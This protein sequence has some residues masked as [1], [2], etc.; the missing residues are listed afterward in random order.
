MSCR[1]PRLKR[2]LKLGALGG[3]IIGVA[4]FMKRRRQNMTS[5]SSWPTLADTAAEQGHSV[6]TSAEHTP[7]EDAADEAADDPGHGRADEAVSDE[8]V[9][10][11]SVSSTA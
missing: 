5:E 2:L 1:M 9:S 8:E 3:V 10:E 4:R 7:S 6:D 11:K